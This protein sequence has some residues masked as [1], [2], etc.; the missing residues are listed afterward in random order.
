MI[1]KPHDVPLSFLSV[2]QISRQ[3]DNAF[4]FYSNFRTLT[5]K[6]L[7]NQETHPTFEGSY[8]RNA[9][10]DLVKIWW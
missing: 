8:L 1:L 5:K 6:Y 4:V 9:W 3:S 10:H 2:H 7:K